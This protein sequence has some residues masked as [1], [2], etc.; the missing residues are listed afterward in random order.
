VWRTRHCFLYQPEHYPENDD[1]SRRGE[2][3]LHN[4]FSSTAIFESS[5]LDSPYFW[6][7]SQELLPTTPGSVIARARLRLSPPFAFSG[8]PDNEKEAFC[9]Q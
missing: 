9:Y 7:T 6:N 2:N 3:N 4:L 1:D 8:M 5:L